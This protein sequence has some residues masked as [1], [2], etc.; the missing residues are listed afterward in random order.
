MSFR[1]NSVKAAKKSLLQSLFLSD[2]RLMGRIITKQKA[3]TIF[4]NDLKGN[5]KSGY[6]SCQDFDL[7]KFNL[8]YFTKEWRKFNFKNLCTNFG[9]DG[10]RPANPKCGH[11]PD[12]PLYN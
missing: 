3:V 9:F 6:S 5:A 10:V 11:M 2:L 4:R 8:N 7:S 12:W 1:S